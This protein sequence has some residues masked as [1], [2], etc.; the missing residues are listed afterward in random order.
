[1]SLVWPLGTLD[2]SAAL[3]LGL[4]VG[5]LVAELRRAATPWHRALLGAATL[6][7]ALPH[8][9]LD[10]RSVW[11]AGG[12]AWLIVHRDRAGL[13]L[14]GGIVLGLAMARAD[15][16]TVATWPVACVPRRLGTAMPLAMVALG[17]FGLGLAVQPT[18]RGPGTSIARVGPMWVGIAAAWLGTWRPPRPPLY[19]LPSALAMWGLAAAAT[20]TALHL[21]RGGR[22]GRDRRIAIGLA[23]GAGVLVTVRTQPLLGGAVCGQLLAPLAIL[24]LLALA[25]IR[26]VEAAPAPARLIDGLLLAQL[27]WMAG[28]AGA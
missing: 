11:A 3:G 10:P 24:W 27:V 21:M 9:D 5:L 23:V 14:P 26:L 16:T 20:G 8:A 13:A 2:L 7:A 25:Q 15:V 1:M 18:G 19:N 4:A 28:F 17:A 22:P 6:V 12:L